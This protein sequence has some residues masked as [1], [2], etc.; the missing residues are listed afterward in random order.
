MH[1]AE[2]TTLAAVVCRAPMLEVIMM[3]G[4]AR[5]GNPDALRNGDVTTTGRIPVVGGTRDPS[6]GCIARGKP[7]GYHDNRQ[8][9]DNKLSHNVLLMFLLHFSSALPKEQRASANLRGSIQVVMA[10]NRF[11]ALYDLGYG[12]VVGTYRLRKRKK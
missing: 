7:Q 2:V 9:A 3:I 5:V 12:Y 6:C 1:D 8:S 11:T 10:D 4:S